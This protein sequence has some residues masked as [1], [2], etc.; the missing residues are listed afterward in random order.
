MLKCVDVKARDDIEHPSVGLADLLRLSGGDRK[1]IPEFRAHVGQVDTQHKHRLFALALQGP[2]QGRN[3][4]VDPCC[5]FQPPPFSQMGLH[6]AAQHRQNLERMGTTVLQK[7]QLELDRMFDAVRPIFPGQFAP[8]KI[9]PGMEKVAVGFHDTQ[10]G[11]EILLGGDEKTAPSIMG[12]AENDKQI[13]LGVLKQLTVRRGIGSGS[14]PQIDVRGQDAQQALAGAIRQG[15]VHLFQFLQHAGAVR[16]AV[17]SLDLAAQLF[18]IS[19]ISAAGMPGLTDGRAA[20]GFHY[21]LGMGVIILCRQIVM[22]IQSAGDLPDPLF[23]DQQRSELP[24][25]FFLDVGNGMHPVKMGDDIK[26]QRRHD[27]GRTGNFQGIANV[28]ILFTILLKRKGVDIANL[29]TI[30][31]IRHAVSTPS[32]SII[33]IN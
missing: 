29:G 4:M 19:F 25:K 12:H 18:R 10:R 26:L 1:V 3:L 16:R 11:F 21:L 20:E 15:A 14:H 5:I 33:R 13:R 31:S 23:G 27:Q 7:G 6:R 32:T 9:L 30:E 24:G 22:R 2:A 8:G 17:E 28:D